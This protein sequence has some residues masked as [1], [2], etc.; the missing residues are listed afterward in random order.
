MIIKLLIKIYTMKKILFLCFVAGSM[1][2]L[3]NSCEKATIDQGSSSI[4]YDPN[5]P[6]QT[7][8]FSA[9]ILPIF[10]SNCMSCHNTQTPVLEAGVAYDNLMNGYVVAG[11]PS[12]SLLYEKLTA[13]N[14]THLGRSSEAQQE[15]IRLWISQGAL[16]N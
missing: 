8:H 16:N 1:T 3:F 9:D 6:V 11:S 13:T 14:T 7:M 12:T 2:V 10:S 15:K 5:A 4:P